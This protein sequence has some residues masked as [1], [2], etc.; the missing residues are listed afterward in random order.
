M[1]K[2]TLSLL[3]LAG[4]VLAFAPGAHALSF[5]FSDQN[6]LGGSSWGTMT[7]EAFDSDTLSVRYDAAPDSVIPA[8]SQATAF[9]FNFDTNPSAVANPGDDTFTDDRNDL[10]WNVLNNLNAI[11]NP[12]N[13]DE[14]TPGLT[15]S[16][17][18]SGVTEGNSNNISTP[19]ILP[20]ESDVFYI[21]FAGVD[22]NSI[23]L[24]E[25]VN[26]A[27]VRLQSLPGDINQG[28]LFLAGNG[29]NGGDPVPEPATALLLG[30]GLFGLAALRRRTKA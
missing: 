13:G 9:G 12:A 14:F 19:G 21:D 23:A 1:R 30:S 7:I 18:T 27:G 16:D 25:F 17:F 3:I 11:P 20:G 24:E 22:F 8:G 4:A 10:Q 6:F 2:K 15:K 29:G 5:S 28:S 26:L